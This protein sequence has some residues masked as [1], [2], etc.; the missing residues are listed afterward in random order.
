MAGRGER[1]SPLP[2][3]LSF[4]IFIEVIEGALPGEFGGCFVV[5]RRR[6]VMKAV[7]GFRIDVPFMLDPIG[8]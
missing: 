1:F 8:L 3:S 5:S 2:A 6:V 4:Q 7:T